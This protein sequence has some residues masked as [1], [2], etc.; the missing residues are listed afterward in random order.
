[1]TA[2]RRGGGREASP[3]SLA[4]GVFDCPE[5]EIEDGLEDDKKDHLAAAFSI[6]I[7]PWMV[8]GIIDRDDRLTRR[9]QWLLPRALARAWSGD[10]DAEPE[11]E[12]GC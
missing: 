11:P 7:V 10:F 5:V 2:V 8:M 4:K 3:R 6:V 12:P 9:G 1:M